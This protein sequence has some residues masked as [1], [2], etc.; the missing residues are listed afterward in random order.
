M[1]RRRTLPSGDTNAL[2]QRLERERDEL[3]DDVLRLRRSV[4]SLTDQLTAL[5]SR[6]RWMEET[7]SWTITRPLR[8]ATAIA[9]DVRGLGDLTAL[10]E[11]GLLGT[12]QRLLRGRAEDDGAATEHGRTLAEILERHAHK[13]IFVAPPRIDWNVPLFQRPQQ[14]AK[15]LGLEGALYFYATNNAAFDH[16]SGFEERSPGCFVTDQASLI[17]ALPNKTLHV[18]ST[19][20][21]LTLGRLKDRLANGDGVL[22]DYIDEIH[23]DITAG[24]PV[25]RL[26]LERHYGLLSD[27]RVACSATA[28]KLLDDVRQV[29]EHRYALVT[30]GVDVEHFKRATRRPVPESLAAVATRGR[31]IIGYYGALA[32]WFDYA[33]INRAAA[34]R[35]KYEFVLIGENYDGTLQRSGVTLHQNVTVLPPVS[36]AE[37][38][39]HAQIFDVSMIPFIVNDVTTATSPVKLFEYMALGT[40]I[41]TTAMRECRKYQSCIIAEAMADFAPALDLALL[42]RDDDQYLATLEREASENSWRAKARQILTLTAERG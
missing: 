2:I 3:E 27:P 33:L 23:P 7:R 39:S 30:N 36:Y 24:A 31:P 10:R 9:R 28:D 8:I 20:H 6:L 15:A 34:E 40:P 11:T 32:S 18:M 1:S 4:A 17:E 38:P 37:L 19:D 42:R 22:Y 25:P 29:R 41:V 16:V 5:K 26:V 21:Q 35:P 12:V 13:P 14:V